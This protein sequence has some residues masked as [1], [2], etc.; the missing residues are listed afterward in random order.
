MLRG[1]WPQVDHAEDALCLSVVQVCCGDPGISTYLRL[2]DLQMP[3]SWLICPPQD[4]S[5]IAVVARLPPYLSS[6]AEP[7]TG[8]PQLRSWAD[9]Q[10]AFALGYLG[11]GIVP[12]AA[13]KHVCLSGHCQAVLWGHGG[14]L[15]K[16]GSLLLWERLGLRTLELICALYFPVPEAQTCFM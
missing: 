2:K 6:S 3:R 11:W 5:R 13:P 1:I 8:R 12:S 15:E 7:N 16:I 4:S 10:H 14:R 9:W